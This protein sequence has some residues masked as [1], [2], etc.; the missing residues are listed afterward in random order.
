MVAL[1]GCAAIAFMQLSIILVDDILDA[2][3]R[4]HHHQIGVGPAA[5]MALAYQALPFQIVEQDVK[6]PERRSAVAANLASMAL[7]TAFGQQLDVQNQGGEENYWRLVRAKSTPF[8]ASALY[9]GAVLGGADSKTAYTLRD[10]GAI[11]GEIVQIQ[12]DLFDAFQTPANP[13]WKQGRN[14]LPILYALTA[15]HPARDRFLELRLRADDPDVLHEAQKILIAC[16]AVSYCIYHLVKRR[17]QA[18]HL[19]DNLSLPDPKPLTDLLTLEMESLI[20]LLKISGV[21]IPPDL[22]SEA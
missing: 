2:D 16:G 15:D 17:R 18:K 20:Q 21:D 9:I 1:P 19:L 11:M 5:N 22:M 8:Y 12:D 14:N 13:D 3:P 7:A 6:D 4:G 10:F